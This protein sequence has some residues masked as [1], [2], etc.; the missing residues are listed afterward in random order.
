MSRDPFQPVWD[1]LNATGFEWSV[2]PGSKHRK[3]KMA[4]FLVAVLGH[5]APSGGDRAIKNTVA[6]VRRAAQQIREGGCAI[7]P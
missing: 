5:R 3:V 4:G 6:Q 7:R 2:E 1:A